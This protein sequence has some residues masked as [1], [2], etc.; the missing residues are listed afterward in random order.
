M[1]ETLGMRTG[2]NIITPAHINYEDERPY[3]VVYLLHGLSDSHTCW[4]D[5]TQLPLF[6][7]EYGVMFIIPEVQRSFYTDMAFGPNYYTYI[8]EEL[9]KI[10]KRL[11]GILDARDNTYIMGLSMG[12]YGALK[13]SLDRPWQYGG[14]AAFSAACDL[15]DAARPGALMSESEIQA[16]CGMEMEIKPEMDVFSLAEKCS[17]SEVKP[18]IYMSCGTEDFIYQMSVKFRD[19]MQNL[20]YDYTYEEWPGE[21][22]WYFWNESLHRALTHFFGNLQ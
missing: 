10:C 13:A 2:L 11:F 3:K 8:T 20:N 5:N 7:N 18:R 12:G 16:I 1:S 22:N 19:F 6:S 21:H 4:S 9:P 17:Q 14:C 15:R